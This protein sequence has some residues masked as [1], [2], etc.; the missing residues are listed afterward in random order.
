MI[1]SISPSASIPISST[2]CSSACSLI[3]NRERAS[4]RL[5]EF[6]QR[7]RGIDH[8]R[9]FGPSESSSVS[10]PSNFLG[11]ERVT[12]FTNQMADFTRRELFPG[13]QFRVGTASGPASFRTACA[14][15]SLRTPVRLQQ[16][17]V[18]LQRGK[19]QDHRG[20]VVFLPVQQISAIFN[21]L[22]TFRRGFTA[23]RRWIPAACGKMPD[24]GQA[25][26]PPVPAGFLIRF[27][28]R[29]PAIPDVRFPLTWPSPLKGEGANNPLSHGER[30]KLIPPR[31]RG[32][33]EAMTIFS[34]QQVRHAVRTPGASRT[35]RPFAQ[36][37]LYGRLRSSRYAASL[38]DSS[39][40]VGQEACCGAC[41]RAGYAALAVLFQFGKLDGGWL[42]W[43]S[44]SGR[45]QNGSFSAAAL[46][47][48]RAASLSSKLNGAW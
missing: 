17:S 29:T 46:A 13:Q 41:T 39:Q 43:N 26:S 32:L 48:R 36:P 15:A 40:A 37:P 35:R 7:G 30:S 21:N 33:S 27:W 5:Q 14:P 12:L 2:G 42:R 6:E 9:W 20:A 22:L 16:R 4:Y 25:Q 19:E 24:G 10:P 44:A 31:G 23:P 28:F 1:S 47:S 11:A 8:L 34:R 38:R 18:A 3:P 45:R